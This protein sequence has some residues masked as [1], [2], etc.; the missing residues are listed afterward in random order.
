MASSIPPPRVI[1][2]DTPVVQLHSKTHFPIK[3]NNTNFAIWQRQVQSTLIGLDLLG[4]VDGSVATPSCSQ[5]DGTFNPCYSVWYRQDQSIIGAL[6][7][8][9]SDT[10]QPLI[11]NTGTAR[12]AWLNL[13][14]SF[15]SASRGRVL[16]LKSKLG[17]N[18]RGNRSIT[19]YLYEMRS[20]ANELALV[21]N[22]ISEEDLVVHVLNQVGK[23]Y[24][25]HTSGA[26]FREQTI[27]FTELGDVLRDI[28]EKLQASDAA[29]QTI[30]ATANST[31][32]ATLSKNGQSW[33][34]DAPA[35][36]GGG[37]HPFNGAGRTSPRDGGCQF[38]S[39]P[40]HDIKRLDYY[41]LKQL[42]LRSETY[43]GVIDSMQMVVLP[44]RDGHRVDWRTTPPGF[45]PQKMHIWRNFKELSV[46]A[47]E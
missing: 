36:H 24:D 22:P 4:F 16:S 30:V 3:L 40:G 12:E 34:R 25:P 9:C 44:C 28:E 11:S 47:W 31:Q 39:I 13:H 37:R 29:T 17:K 20:L 33:P 7:G 18:P 19:E 26:R 46:L 5:A 43:Q 32:R 15:A 21:Q 23:A 10:I 35:Y 14:S 2:K 27:S 41:R 38:C 42:D 6:L 1:T 45:D 8:S